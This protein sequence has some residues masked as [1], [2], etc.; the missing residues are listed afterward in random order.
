[1]VAGSKTVDRGQRAS[2][3]WPSLALAPLTGLRLQE[4][5]VLMIIYPNVNNTDIRK[6]MDP[7]ATT[8]GNGD[9]RC[10]ST[11]EASP[12]RILGPQTPD[13]PSHKTS[14]HSIT[15]LPRRASAGRLVELIGRPFSQGCLCSLSCMNSHKTAHPCS[16]QVHQ[17]M[18]IDSDDGGLALDDMFTV[19]T[20]S[21]HGV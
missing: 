18:S 6:L 3:G 11:R 17:A 19:C 2:T 12:G 5:T 13:R 20:A 10:Y 21:L 1:M 9:V 15:L 8:W 7:H 16:W 14:V 4:P